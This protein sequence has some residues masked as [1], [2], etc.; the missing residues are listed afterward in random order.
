MKPEQSL[1][2]LSRQF[3]SYQYRHEP[4]PAIDAVLRLP[5]RGLIFAW[6]WLL[7]ACTVP[8]TY[9]DATTYRNLTELK[10][11]AMTL[12]ETFDAVPF[13]RNEAGIQQLRL[14]FRK[15][16]EYELGKGEPNSD[17]ARQ[18]GE[19]S[20]LIDAVIRDYRESQPGELGAKYFA[21]AAVQLGQAFDIAIRTENE[22]N[23]DKR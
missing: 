14:A 22:K 2:S 6:L 1:Q 13:K 17:T 8:I 4:G 10:A 5:S 18:F 21:Q 19:I 12:V 3:A 20:K 23:A 9:Y 11:E 15:A 7:T 16:H